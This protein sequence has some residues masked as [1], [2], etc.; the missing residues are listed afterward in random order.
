MKMDSNTQIK[1]RFNGKTNPE[2]DWT[3]ACTRDLIKHCFTDN[4][5]GGMVPYLSQ[6]CKSP[7]S[8]KRNVTIIK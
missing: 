8:T 7:A 5:M 4:Q 3:M 1:A 2:G 6:E